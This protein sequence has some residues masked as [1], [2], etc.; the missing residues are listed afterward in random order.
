LRDLEQRGERLYATQRE[1]VLATGPAPLA[2]LKPDA[3]LAVWRRFN[4]EPRA[5][6]IE[7]P[8]ITRA[9]VDEKRAIILDALRSTAVVSFR[10]MAGDTV[11]DVIATFLAVLEL[12][13]R[14]L[15]Y[16]EQSTPFGDLELRQ[17]G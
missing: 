9:S 12:F 8:G 5:S 11:D 10:S 3:L 6:Q 15:I 2:P 14:G 4:E 7:L 13:R 17:L 1:P 16:V